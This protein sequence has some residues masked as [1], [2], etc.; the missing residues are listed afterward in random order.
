MP[1]DLFLIDTVFIKLISFP[2]TPCVDD[3]MPLFFFIVQKNRN[4][5]QVFTLPN[6]FSR[7]RCWLHITGQLEDKLLC[8]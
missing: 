5:I 1:I 8:K 6:P 4:P 2:S 3:K 7:Q